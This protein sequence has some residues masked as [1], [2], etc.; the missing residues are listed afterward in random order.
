MIAMQ[1]WNRLDCDPSTCTLGSSGYGSWLIYAMALALYLLIPL[2]VVCIVQV[3]VL[4]I[5]DANRPHDLA[6]RAALGERQASAVRAA[7]TRGLRDGVLWVGGA[8]VVAGLL[9]SGLLIA[10]GW[11]LT[12]QGDLW[13]VRALVGAVVVA[14]LALAHVIDTARPRRTPVERLYEEAL[15]PQKRRGR[16]IL[17]MALAGVAACAA[18]L[19]VGLALAHELAPNFYVTNA[20]GIAMAIVWFA[21]VSLALF[22]LIPWSRTLV[23]SWLGNVARLAHR[24]V[25]PIVEA[26]AA[27]AS[28]ASGRLVIVLGSLAFAL[29]SA[30]SADSALSLSDTY[31]GNRIFMEPH[32]SA[33]FAERLRQ[34]DGVAD[35]VVAD[36]QDAQSAYGSPSTLFAVDPEQLRGLDDTL[37]G[38]LTRHPGALVQNLW[39]SGATL[40]QLSSSAYGFMP[41][42]VVP[43]AT[44]CDMF[45]SSS[46]G[47]T[48]DPT[49]TAYLIYST[50]P[51]LNAA[52]VSG[53][54]GLTPAGLSPQGPQGSSITG[55]VSV[56]LSASLLS[57]GILVLF[58]GAPVV[59][60]A[61]GLART[62]R[63]DDATLAALGATPR[64]LR[65]A[66]VFETASV[67]A[68][69]VAF[70]G[71]LG[72][73]TR[74]TMTALGRANSSLT[75]VITDSYLATALGSVAWLALAVALMGAVA[76]VSVTA[77]LAARRYRGASPVEGLRPLAV[78]GPR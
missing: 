54:W 71:G 3:A 17:G 22:V 28:R 49:A 51:A 14:T 74:A 9:H 7:A 59:A 77:W 53:A 47:M 35:V 12:T 33:A 13:L 11:P 73:L 8:Y 2:I 42:G 15:P 19:V 63:G 29:G 65:A 39:W 62:R 36:V 45:T 37:A 70:G 31:V 60:L 61:V 6:V 68:F 43:I 44:C 4:G 64:A 27:S 38:I 67:A 72:A 76:L 69:A 75:G 57:I 25:A 55:D 10:S 16:R 26:R 58:I 1:P 32:D 20:T 56:S 23:P 40:H 50:D 41:T 18:G 24:D 78:G 46:A 48:A 21:V 34:V 30:A 5:R 66:T 52:V